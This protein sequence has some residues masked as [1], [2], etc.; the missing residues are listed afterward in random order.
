M[1][2]L[3]PPTF[4]W[5]TGSGPRTWATLLKTFMKITTEMQRLPMFSSYSHPGQENGEGNMP[6]F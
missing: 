2:S 5:S 4:I 6:S 1:V 3:A